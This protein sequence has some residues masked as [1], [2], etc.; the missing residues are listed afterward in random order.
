MIRRLKR[1]PSVETTVAIKTVSQHAANPEFILTENQEEDASLVAAVP[2][3]HE[4]PTERLSCVVASPL[5]SKTFT[6]RRMAESQLAI[7]ISEGRFLSISRPFREYR[8]DKQELESAMTNIYNI[9]KEQA[10]DG[11]VGAIWYG[12][13]ELIVEYV[14]IAHRDR[15]ILNLL[16]DAPVLD[17]QE[18]QAIGHG[19]PKLYMSWVVPLQKEDTT[20][21]LANALSRYFRHSGYSSLY[22]YGHFGLPSGLLRIIFHKPPPVL[23]DYLIFG[24]PYRDRKIQIEAVVRNT[25]P[26]HQGRTSCDGI[27]TEAEDGV[28]ERTWPIEND[29]R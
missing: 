19:G 9:V 7:L 26:L 22:T 24:V 4:Y 1:T 25:F 3:H 20:A 8:L 21:A 11:L 28:A 13:D 5:E 2:Q 12:P 15:A 27:P 6:A 23:A 29:F 16:D 17:K 14:T 10:E 18:I